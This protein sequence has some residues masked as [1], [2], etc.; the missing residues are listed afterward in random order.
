MPCPA[1]QTRVQPLPRSTA[2][3][4]SLEDTILDHL[5]LEVLLV[6]RNVAVP[7][8]YRLVLAHHDVLR[9]LVEQP[10]PC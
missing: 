3:H 2:T 6:F 1:H 8:A 4:A 9:N 7:L 10:E 5:L